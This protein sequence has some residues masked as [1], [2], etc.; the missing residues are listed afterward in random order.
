MNVV[1]NILLG[2]HIA[3]GTMGLATG[4]YNLFRRKGDKQHRTAGRIFTVGMYTAGL[5]ALG[6]SVLHLNYFLFIVGIFT[7]Y[8]TATG[9]RYLHLKGMDKGQKPAFIDKVLTSAMLLMS[10]LFIALG[11]MRVVV[12]RDN[13][14][15]VFFVFGIIA[16]RFVLADLNH[17]RGRIK[18]KNYW[19]LAHLQR[20]TGSY[21]AAT[22]AFLVV[23]AKY[24]PSSIPSF[25][26]WLLPTV[27][28]TPL[29]VKWS[30]KYA[31]RKSVG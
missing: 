29:I 12:N 3:G 16:L 7:L 28:L 1:F 31:V 20:M 18:I 21:I 10:I 24:L 9:N 17:Y 30:A 25:V 14:G 22:T 27:I 26:T 11:T 8:M 23:N 4:T 19:L 5:S 15:V 6:L 2:L 13:F